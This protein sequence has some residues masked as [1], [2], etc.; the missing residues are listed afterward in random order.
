[1]Q[2]WPGGTNDAAMGAEQGELVRQNSSGEGPG[3]TA[4]HWRVWVLPW[5]KVAH[6]WVQDR[7]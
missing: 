1:M 5:E 3:V 2:R 4:G 6:S 7:V